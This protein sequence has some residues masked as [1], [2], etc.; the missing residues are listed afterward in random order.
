MRH[1][2][3]VLLL[4][5]QAAFT[6]LFAQTGNSL[7]YSQAN[8][9]Y[10]QNFNGLPS[11]GS[12][13]LSGKG[14]H[15]FLTSPFAISAMAGWEMMQRSG[16]G[17]NAVFS[18]GTGSS[19]AAGVYSVGNSGSDRA[20]GTQSAGTGIYSIG[21]IITNQTGKTLHKIN[22][23]FTAEQWRKGGSG[24]ANT[25]TG[26]IGT[27]VFNGINAG[28]LN[29][30]PSLNFSSVQSSTG[31]GS[32]NGNN[33]ENQSIIQ[34]NIGGLTWKNGE[35][36]VLLWEDTDE[37]GSDDLM[38]IDDLSFRADADSTGNEQVHID[39]LHST[40][41]GITNADTIQYAFKPSGD[42][43]GLS[44]HNFVLHTQG[45]GNAA[46][47]EVTG[48]GTDYYI[49][50]FTGNGEGK[51]VL[52]IN[53]ND[54]LIPGLTGLPFF[55][56]DTQLID[57][58]KPI[59][60]NLIPLSDS[61]LK[62]GDTLTLQLSFNE[63][64]HLDSLS[65]LQSIPIQISNQIKQAVY[66]KG[67][68][69]NQLFFRY[70]IE[71][72]DKDLDGIQLASTYNP[73][74]TIIKDPAENSSELS[75]NSSEIQHI[76]INGIPIQYKEARDSTLLLCN[77]RDSIDIAPILAIDS[78]GNGEIL[79]WK[80]TEGSVR[81]DGNQSSFSKMSSGGIVQPASI[82]YA[83]ANVLAADSILVSVSN[84]FTDTHKKIKLESLSWMG[85]IDSNWH[86]PLNWCNA[87]VP[88]SNAYITIGSNTPYQPH[89]LQKHVVGN[90][91]IASG[92]K[93]NITGT[94]QLMGE[95]LGDSASIDAKT[96]NIEL[97]GV[98]AQELN[99]N[100]F[101]SK[102]IGSLIVNNNI[103]LT[104]P[105]YI[106]E[107]VQLKSGHLQTNDQLYFNVSAIISPAAQGVTVSGNVFAANT[108]KQKSAG[109]YLAGHPFTDSISLQQWINAPT[110]HWN[111]SILN[112]D[113]FSIE[114]GWQLLAQGNEN[115]WKQQQG[116]RWNIGN[117][118]DKNSWAD[119]FRGNILVG[120]HTKN[121]SSSGNGFQLVSNPYLSPINSA[122]IVKGNSIQNYKYVWDSQ[123][124]NG[125]GYTAIPY[126]QKHI[127]NPFEAIILQTDSTAG[128]E[129]LFSEAAKSNEWNNGNSEEFKELNGYFTNIQLYYNQQIQDRL[130]IREQANAK[131]GKDIF[132]ASKLLN[133]GLNIFSYSSDNKKLAVDSRVFSEQ[134]RIPI[135]L[136]NLLNGTY[137]LKIADAYMPASL[138]LVLYDTY[139][140]QQLELLKD[141][142]I[143]F[144]VN[145]D[146]SSRSN[147]RF[148]IAKWAPRAIVPIANLLTVK[149][150]PNPS[151]TE[152]NV[153]FK[154]A[155]P[156]NSM[157][158]IFNMEGTLLK[159]VAV[160]TTQQGFIR[161]PLGNLT[162]GQYLL[163]V[164]S[165]SHQQNIPFF[166]Q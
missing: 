37:G 139:S 93:L 115:I 80:I 88:D 69:S 15:S 153:I 3:F 124:G 26:K 18:I 63:S 140:N 134:T 130:I 133:P 103:T 148:F 91:W 54:N 24:N 1:H 67:N 57:K 48:S 102:T 83:V 158:R 122:L 20:L 14:P 107:S 81:W 135:E 16:S 9:I 4:L 5:F 85:T 77:T 95:L 89:I 53:N 30:A 70:I 106:N 150:Y 29:L 125:G 55:S 68:H 42:L 10:Q 123:L 6:H 161:I 156:G 79:T 75:M 138:K 76:R 47:T 23:S 146:S 117:N 105:L 159:T 87:L 112:T 62:K 166:K 59:H 165:G 151:S 96:G 2:L 160:G 126:N 154:A 108:F 22:G 92:A 11:S 35:Q 44:T 51:M 61:M 72:N 65:P 12:Y 64:V 60:I 116:I 121:L 142:S 114:A 84:G 149:I 39:S 119:Y 136:S 164:T 109:I 46:I 162:N 101:K 33:P 49:K 71:S 36:L 7:I 98:V 41:S 163:Q 152:L 27:G 157:I 45:L 100:I 128:N 21:L 82:K 66:W 147:Q 143:R 13:L 99:G 141:S 90:L 118:E 38:A 111:N 97:N 34:F 19:T 58:I 50:I 73:T 120:N 40:S 78:T 129:L 31:A 56:I 145:S 32:L 104:N 74:Q 25:W 86:N 155:V 127:L 131:N 113:S 137:Q 94:L 52:G 110:I 8:A 43:T 144:D 17:S 28:T 132:D